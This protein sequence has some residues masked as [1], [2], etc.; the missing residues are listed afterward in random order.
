M[1]DQG[2]HLIVPFYGQGSKKVY[3]Y[4]F[5][6]LQ[7]VFFCCGLG[8]PV[9]KELHITNHWHKNV[10][11]STGLI[12]TVAAVAVPVQ[13]PVPVPDPVLAAVAVAVVVAVAV[14]VAVAVV[15]VGCGLQFK[16]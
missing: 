16:V 1:V 7:A 3:H 8:I 13:A 2:Q 4:N 6:Y 11:Y 5:Y 9:C 10:A 14:A 15:V 12:C